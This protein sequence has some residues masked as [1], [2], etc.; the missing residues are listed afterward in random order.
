M[1][2]LAL[3]LTSDSHAKLNGRGGCQLWL[4]KVVKM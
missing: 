2:L 4:P 3:A 1:A